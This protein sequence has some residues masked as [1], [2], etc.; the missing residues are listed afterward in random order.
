MHKSGCNQVECVFQPIELGLSMT[1][2]DLH[3]RPKDH[4][5]RFF[6]QQKVYHMENNKAAMS[7]PLKYIFAG[8]LW[9]RYLCMSETL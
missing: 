1:G 4:K 6:E 5:N 2:S 3:K 8:I 9:V 7:G